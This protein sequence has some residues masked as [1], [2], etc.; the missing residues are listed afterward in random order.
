MSFENFVVGAKCFIP[1]SSPLSRESL[2]SLN[3]Q[4]EE[5]MRRRGFLLMHTDPYDFALAEARLT[6]EF[7][8]A[9][10]RPRRSR[11]SRLR[12]SETRA[13]REQ[14]FAY[15]QGKTDA[16][17]HILLFTIGYDNGLKGFV[18]RIE[19]EPA[20]V[21]KIKQLHHKADID[22]VHYDNIIW[23]NKRSMSEIIHSVG[24]RVLVEPEVIRPRERAVARPLIETSL[25]VTL[26]G[27]VAACIEEANRCFAAECFLACS[28]MIRKSIEVGVTKKLQQEGRHEWLYDADGHERGLGKKLDLLPEIAP[29]LARHMGEIKLVKWLGDVSAHD[30]RTQITPADLQVVAPLIKTFLAD[31]QLKR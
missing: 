28:I 24:A 3:R 29:R 25:I 26:P 15:L 30:P 12:K 13:Y 27:E 21:S 17:P 19:S 18:L 23:E 6:M 4:L 2:N 16:A 8:S 10:E 7:S 5:V 20:I 9:F 11:L 22:D 31:L 14:Y 1:S